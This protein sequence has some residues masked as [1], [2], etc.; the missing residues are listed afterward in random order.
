MSEIPTCI[1]K[2]TTNTDENF[3][4]PLAHKPCF[5]LTTHCDEM[6][7]FNSKV[8]KHYVYQSSCIKLNNSEI[9]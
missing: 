5:I 2:I 3:T 9:K 8:A 4:Q 1:P 6:Y 7:S